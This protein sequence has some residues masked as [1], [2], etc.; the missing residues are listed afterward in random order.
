MELQICSLVKVTPYQ[1]TATIIGVTLPGKRKAWGIRVIIVHRVDTSHKCTGGTGNQP[2]GMLTLQLASTVP[3][4]TV[5]L[6]VRRRKPGSSGP[7][8]TSP[9]GVNLIVAV[10][11]VI[12]AI[13]SAHT[14]IKRL[15][16]MELGCV[17]NMCP[18]LS[19]SS[20]HYD[21]PARPWKS[22]VIK[23]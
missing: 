19:W 3:P 23:H 22:A 2:G 8:G 4:D 15:L 21:S 13:N 14:T 7:T 5:R 10:V 12:Y 18:R 6:P 20:C 1:P 9:L 17:G 16:S 11:V